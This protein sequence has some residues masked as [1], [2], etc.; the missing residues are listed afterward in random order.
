[1]KYLL[2]ERQSFYVP[3]QFIF[4][5]ILQDLNEIK[6]TVTNKKCK[7]S[8]RTLIAFHQNLYHAFCQFSKMFETKYLVQKSLFQENG[9]QNV[10]QFQFL[11]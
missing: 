4:S 11:R 6:K 10:S 2:T 7:S 5:L 9:N 8:Y 1:M 3:T